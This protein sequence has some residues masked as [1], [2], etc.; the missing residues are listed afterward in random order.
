MGYPVQHSFADNKTF[1]QMG[2]N[3]GGAHLRTNEGRSHDEVKP[4]APCS[5]RNSDRRDDDELQCRSEAVY[6]EVVDVDS[7]FFTASTNSGSCS[8]DVTSRS[9]CSALLLLVLHTVMHTPPRLLCPSSCDELLPTTS[10]IG[11]L[12]A[13][14]VVVVA[15]SVPVLVVVLVMR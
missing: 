5:T 13:G 11:R 14:L 3:V 1:E 15:L 7:Q 4:R 10:S 9:S 12:G 8:R 6:T 2:L